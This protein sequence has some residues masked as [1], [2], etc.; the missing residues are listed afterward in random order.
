MRRG[1]KL[2]NN[3]AKNLQLLR[4]RNNLTQ[5]KLVH[6]LNSKYT[7]MELQR[8]SIVSYETEGSMPKIDALY[9][10]ADYFS[11]TM[12]QL[13]SPTM[14]K[15]V[16]RHSWLEDRIL[17]PGM[18]VKGASG[19][20]CG[21]ENAAQQALEVNIDQILTTCADGI[22][23]RQ[24][25]TE[26]LKSLYQ[27]LLDNANKEE[28]AKIENIFSKTFLGC[29]VNKSKYMRDAAEN[30]LPEPEFSVYMA[31]S[32]K[33][34]DIQ[35]VANGLGMTKEEVIAAFNSAQTKMSSIFEASLKPI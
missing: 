34:A 35:T 19:N 28:Q 30:L 24:F 7:D 15:P 5:A 25:H 27:Q 10:I 8:T 26:F 20:N 21:I 9:C 13:V 29:L 18:K 2:K 14:D 16:L 22:A 4:T 12:D 11:K 17:E 23:H 32:N 3:F 31:F 33:G 6:E 1:D